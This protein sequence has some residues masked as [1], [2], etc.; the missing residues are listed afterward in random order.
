[1]QVQVH[2]SEFAK[3]EAIEQHVED[4][5]FHLAK[6]VDPIQVH[7][8]LKVDGKGRDQICKIEFHA[9]HKDFTATEHSDNMYKSIDLAV[10]KIE[11]QLRKEHDMAVKERRHSGSIKTATTINPLT[12]N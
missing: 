5:M 4:M 9:K 6:F 3:T 8:F 2:Y 1:M 12:N 11:A 7:V 10:H